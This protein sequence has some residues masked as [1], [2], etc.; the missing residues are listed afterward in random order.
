MNDGKTS[1]KSD[2]HGLGVIIIELVAGRKVVNDSNSN[3]RVQ[4]IQAFQEVF[5]HLVLE[6]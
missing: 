5:Y 4:F 2:I 1:F 6:Q 3:V